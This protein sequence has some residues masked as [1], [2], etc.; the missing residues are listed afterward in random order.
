MADN[1]ITRARSLLEAPVER[2]SSL[3]LLLAAGMAALGAILMAGVMILG[4][5]VNLADGAA[6][7][8]PAPSAQFPHG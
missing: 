1:A 6:S 8:A 4:P 7:E 5:G 2:A 3:N